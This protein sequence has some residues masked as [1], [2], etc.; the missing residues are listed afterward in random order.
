MKFTIDNPYLLLSQ[1]INER[2]WGWG[3]LTDIRGQNRNVSTIA[4]GCVDVVLISGNVWRQLTEKG[5]KQLRMDLVH[6]GILVNRTVTRHGIPPL[7]INFLSI[8]C[9]HLPS[10]SLCLII[11][12]YEVVTSSPTCYTYPLCRADREKPSFALNSLIHSRHQ[13]LNIINHWW[14]I[15]YYYVVVNRSRMPHNHKVGRVARLFA[16][17]L[18]R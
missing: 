9:S 2:L 16:S 10:Y 15:T 8:M 1:S 14:T 7:V 13:A 4:V 6:L 11:A 5:W 17:L 18:V 12:I 3:V